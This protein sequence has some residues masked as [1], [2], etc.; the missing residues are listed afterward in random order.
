MALEIIGAGFGRTGT[1]SLKFA[2]EH[3]GFVK[4]HHMTSLAGNRKLVYAW[5]DV[6]L[7][8]SRDWDALFEGFRAT[9]D[10]PST[11]YYRELMEHYPDAKVILTARDA[12]SWY[13]SASETIYAVSRALPAWFQWIRPLAANSEMVEA[14]IWQGEFGGRFEDSQAAR[15]VFRKHVEDVKASVPAERLLVFNV[16]DGW[17]PLCEFLG[18]PVPEDRPFPHVNDSSVIKRAIRIIRIAGMVPYVLLA[19]GVLWSGIGFLL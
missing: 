17:E 18:V 5:H 14:T 11:A 15:E 13:R 7:K 16:R 19:A 4:C 12:E 10:W 8:G 6:A 1:M 2:L 9:V 3:L